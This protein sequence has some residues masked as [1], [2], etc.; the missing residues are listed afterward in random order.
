[1]PAARYQFL[2]AA[3][4]ILAVGPRCSLRAD[5]LVLES[6]GRLEGQWLNREEFTTEQYA[7]RRVGVVIV[8]PGTQVREAIQQSPAELEYPRRASLAPDTI[9]GQWALAEWCRTSALT[10]QRAVH[11][12]RIIE[13]DPNHQPARHALGYQFLKGQWIT[14]SA[15][16]RREGYELHQGKWRTPQEIE[17]L[18]RRA[19]EEAIEKD[20]LVRLKKIR[21]DIDLPDKHRLA[22]DTLQTIREPAAAGPI[23]LFFAAERL[24][25]VKALYIEILAR[26]NTPTSID[27]LVDRALNDLDEEVF[28]LC[29]GEII[30][31]NPPHIADPF[32]TAL[33]HNSNVQVNRAAQALARI[34]DRS[35][36]S[37]LIDALTTKHT[38][39]VRQGRGGDST[40]S[41]FTS[42]GTFMKKGDGD[43][44]IV[45]HVQNQPVLDALS[46][47]TAANFGFDQK[48][49]RYWHSQDKLA[50]DAAQ[51][52]LDAR[53]Q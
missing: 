37:P 42:D 23:G 41:A 13:L 29:L 36:I 38:Q 11:L 6:G 47:L 14:I 16:R 19:R 53:R 31:L 18:E 4:L 24:R 2:L 12:Q 26:I 30:K 32:V 35:A 10:A 1:M 50:R 5:V 52:P 46:K 40:T 25:K 28:Y 34:Q 15:A 45:Y 44:V 3:T 33:K 27:V 8:L 7:L 49:W 48:A 20:W 9:A 17:I 21:R 51:S 43:Q 39:V 22:L